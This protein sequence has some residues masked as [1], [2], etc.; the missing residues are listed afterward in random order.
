MD[1]KKPPQFLYAYYTPFGVVAVLFLIVILV[2]F[3]HNKDF[4]REYAISQ[5]PSVENATTTSPYILPKRSLPEL[6][7]IRVVVSQEIAF[8]RALIQEENASVDI[9]P[10]I[11][12]DS[13]ARIKNTLEN[14]PA[15]SQKNFCEKF[16]TFSRTLNTV[17]DETGTNVQKL[18]TAR[19]EKL[20]EDRSRRENRIKRNRDLRDVELDT[21][22]SR[23]EK[24]ATISSTTPTNPIRT[25]ITNALG[26]IRYQT[27]TLSNQFFLDVSQQLN[28]YMTNINDLFSTIN[29]KIA[30]ILSRGKNECAEGISPRVVRLSTHAGLTVVLGK[31]LEKALQNIPYS[32]EQLS[33]LVQTK[34][35]QQ[36]TQVLA[37]DA[38][39]TKLES[40]IE[41]ISKK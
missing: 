19:D 34:E 10:E 39:K 28:T 38:L 40:I 23:I 41:S 37:Q 20:Y 13:F 16:T 5:T 15:D 12:L 7:R 2:I 26:E 11:S 32:K 27:D 31:S 14:L 36:G 8:E 33:L 25:D 22:F 35:V 21:Y 6:E 18:F 24:L 30:Q 3:F 9:I 17:V 29:P 4:S 1:L